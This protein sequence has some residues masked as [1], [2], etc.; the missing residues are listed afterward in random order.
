V[1]DQGRKTISYDSKNGEYVVFGETIL[2]NDGRYEFHGHAVKEWVDLT[3]DQRQHFTSAKVMDERGSLTKVFD[4]NGEL[5]K[6]GTK[7]FGQ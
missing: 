2:H 1:S 5:T 3:H 6:L 4:R 7:L